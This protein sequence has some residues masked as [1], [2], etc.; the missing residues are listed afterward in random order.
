MEDQDKRKLK[1]AA[2]SAAKIAASLLIPG[3]APFVIAGELVKHS[4]GA[5]GGKKMGKTAGIL[6]GPDP[7]ISDG[8]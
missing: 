4:V 5:V 7:D 6:F 3:A 1:E 8:D 2:K